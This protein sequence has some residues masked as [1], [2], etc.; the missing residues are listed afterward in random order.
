[1]LSL[2]NQMIGP[3]YIALIVATAIVLAINVLTSGCKK[4]YCCYPGYIQIDCKQPGNATS[5]GF[6]CAPGDCEA[7]LLAYI[8]SGYICDTV[9]NGHW[10][11]YPGNGHPY[12]CIDAGADYQKA[13]AAGDSCVL[14]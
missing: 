8:D 10:T 12:D 14:D 1:M 2:V 9:F 6:S 13:V 4:C 11:Y 7:Q 3:K 5:Y